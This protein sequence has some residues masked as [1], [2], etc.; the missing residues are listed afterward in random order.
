MAAAA[1]QD[2]VDLVHFGARPSRLGGDKSA[3]ADRMG[4]GDQQKPPNEFKNIKNQRKSTNLVEF[5]P[6]L[7]NKTHKTTRN[8][9]FACVYLHGFSGFFSG[10]CGVE[11]L[12]W[13]KGVRNLS[14]ML[15]SRQHGCALVSGLVGCRG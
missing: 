15:V 10:A 3:D 12:H 14:G 6:A 11:L 5:S 13:T 7:P 9:E 8:F 1:P 2:A 4:A